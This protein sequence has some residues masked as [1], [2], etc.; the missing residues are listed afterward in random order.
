MRV[1][2]DLAVTNRARLSIRIYLFY[3][4]EDS[5]MASNTDV[6]NAFSACWGSMNVDEIMD[7]FTPDAVYTNIPIDP[8]NVGTDAVRA[9]ILRLSRHAGFPVSGWPDALRS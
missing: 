8:P 9:A 6:I 2:L 1:A 7:Y 4:I 5:L 3:L